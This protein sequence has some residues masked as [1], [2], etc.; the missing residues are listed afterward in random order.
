MTSERVLCCFKNLKV[1]PNG[2]KILAKNLNKVL[3]TTTFDVVKEHGATDDEY[4]LECS[5]GEVDYIRQHLSDLVTSCHRSIWFT[6]RSKASD[7]TSEINQFNSSR[8]SKQK[9]WKALYNFG[10]MIGYDRFIGH[11]LSNRSPVLVKVNRDTRGRLKNIVLDICHTKYRMV[12]DMNLFH[13]HI[14]IKYGQDSIDESIK[15]VFMMK[16]LPQIKKPLSNG[17][18]IR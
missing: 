11:I 1:D 9:I 7:Y 5:Q 8:N 13:N 12:F 14:L 18:Y 4:E 15:I 3:N 17:D 2:P 6:Y 16:G 10:S